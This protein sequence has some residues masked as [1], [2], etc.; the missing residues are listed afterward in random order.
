MGTVTLISGDSE[1]R[2][3]IQSLLAKEISLQ[4]FITLDDL[5][6]PSPAASSVKLILVDLAN[7][8][9]TA[10]DLEPF[11]RS[12]IP[13]ISLIDS[14]SERDSALLA[15]FDDY[16]L[17]PF[18]ALE[19]RARV[20]RFAA[21]P[22]APDLARERM[23]TVGRLTSYFCHAVYNS[24]QAIRGAT[25]LALEE[26]DLPPAVSEYLRISRKETFHLAEMVDRLRQIYRPKPGAPESVALISLLRESL[27]MASDELIKNEVRVREEFPPELP[28]LQCR[29]DT[30]ALSFLLL[31]LRLGDS[32]GE[33]GGGGL[34]VKVRQDNGAL[35]VQFFA[36]A[37]PSRTGGGFP[38]PSLFH[39]LEP[40]RELIQAERGEMLVSSA[41]GELRIEI[42]LPAGRPPGAVT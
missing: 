38:S 7:T 10:A 12:G 18:S 31:L 20:L 41:E 22:A 14:P 16:L 30:L 4:K 40:A 1:T 2:K 9:A 35:S 26:S 37:S 3:T 34:R 8:S 39:G 42:R 27:A 11:R 6:L 29:R 19:L 15:G 5:P 32:L 25:D 21:A 17:K 13:L 24:L 33:C 28:D 36:A 23:A